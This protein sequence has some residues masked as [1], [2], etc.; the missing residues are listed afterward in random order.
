M[1]KLN[2]VSFIL[3]GF[4]IFCSTASAGYEIGNGGLVVVCRN[5]NLKISSVEL[6]DVYELR[7]RRGLSQAQTEARYY[8]P[9]AWIKNISIKSPRRALI[10]QTYMATFDQEVS[11][12]E[13]RILPST[14]D[15]GFTM[16]I[17]DNCQLEQLII[18]SVKAHP[19]ESFRKDRYI[20]AKNYWDKMSPLN[21]AAARLHEAV[22]R[23]R[24]KQCI[25][26]TEGNCFPYAFKLSS[27][28]IRKLVDIVISEELLGLDT[29]TLNELFI[30]NGF[31]RVESQ[32]IVFLDTVPEYLKI[33]HFVVNDGFSINKDMI[34]EMDFTPETDTHLENFLAGKFN[35]TVSDFFDNSAVEAYKHNFISVK[36]FKFH[37]ILPRQFKVERDGNLIKITPAS[38]NNSS[39]LFFDETT[40][41]SKFKN[42]FYE[43]TLDMSKLSVNIDGFVYFSGW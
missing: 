28:G 6:L 32:G 29:K 2:I 34:P 12:Y 40:M 17:P 8:K 21:K 3:I 24:I 35:F 14:N 25:D 19:S 9:E 37:L 7:Q 10:Y 20:I 43:I 41:K 30:N 4:K 11:F 38:L 22:W 39:L 42:N 18:Q 33:N 36:F 1:S 31:R 16:K 26:L 27:E 15:S 5:S 13:D 23:E